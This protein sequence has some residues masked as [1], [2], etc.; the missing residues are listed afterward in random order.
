M[1]DKLNS[2]LAL[3][4]DQQEHKQDEESVVDE[5]DIQEGEIIDNALSYFL[6]ISEKT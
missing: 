6:S 5:E 3:I 2:L 4:L 1:N